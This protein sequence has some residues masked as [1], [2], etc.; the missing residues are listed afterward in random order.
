[1][2]T[3]VKTRSKN[4]DKSKVKFV[5][6]KRQNEISGRLSL[7]KKICTNYHNNRA[8]PICFLLLVVFFGKSIQFGSERERANRK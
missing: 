3:E 4:F 1:M 5:I 6:D 2:R 7:V 8:H